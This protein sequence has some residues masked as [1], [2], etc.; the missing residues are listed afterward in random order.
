MCYLFVMISCV[1]LQMNGEWFEIFRTSKKATHKE[2]LTF[3]C[4]TVQYFSTYWHFS[5]VFWLFFFFNI[6]PGGEVLAQFCCPWGWDF[7]L[8]SARGWGSG[9]FKN[10]PGGLPERE[11]VRLRTD[12]YIMP[13][14]KL[15]LSL[16]HESLQTLFLRDDCQTCED[17]C[18]CNIW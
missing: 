5:T 16:R 17:I 4:F 3:I 12:W 11:M 1:G 13:Y 10:L 14:I 8:F 2:A 7:I 18:K 6:C 9:P 15:C